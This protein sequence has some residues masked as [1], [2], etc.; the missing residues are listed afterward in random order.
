MIGWIATVP[1]SLVGAVASAGNGE[2]VAADFRMS[3]PDSNRTPRRLWTDR[4]GQ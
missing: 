4:L 2:S 1:S 3:F